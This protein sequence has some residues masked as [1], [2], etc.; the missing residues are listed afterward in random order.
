VLSNLRPSFARSTFIARH[1]RRNVSVIERACRRPLATGQHD[2]NDE[3]VLERVRHFTDSLPPAPP[4]WVAISAVII[5]IL[6]AQGVFAALASLSLEQIDVRLTGIASPDAT[7]IYD[8]ART[9]VRANSDQLANLVLSLSLSCYFVL[10]GPMSGLRIA[11]MLLNAPRALTRRNRNSPLAVQAEHWDVY[12]EEQRLFTTLRQPRPHNPP[13]D[14]LVK[15]ALFA[16]PWF[17]WVE[18]G[19][20]DLL[21]TLGAIWEVVVFGGP[22]PL[23]FL[24]I[25]LFFA[26][27]VAAPPRLAWLSVAALRRRQGTAL[28][29]A[30]A[31]LTTVPIVAHGAPDTFDF[32]A[33]ERVVRLRVEQSRSV[34]SL[35]SA[36]EAAVGN[37]TDEIELRVRGV[38]LRGRNMNHMNLRGVD[39]KGAQLS[40]ANLAFSRLPDSC[41]QDAVLRNANLAG[42]DLRFADLRGA[43]LRGANLHGAKLK[44]SGFDVQTS[45]PAGYPGHSGSVDARRRDQS[46]CNSR[47]YSDFIGHRHWVGR[48]GNHRPTSP[49]TATL[50]K[51]PRPS[52]PS[53]GRDR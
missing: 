40:D 36:L 2:D 22:Q 26:A 17:L 29:A 51:R 23:A 52:A 27:A 46:R 14:L 43:D 6:L 4:R 30:I 42:A 39:F 31:V 34:E 8:L 38:D 1:V 7:S 16:G 32:D 11:R 21:Y 5:M 25:G 28:L 15:A 18:S 37:G 12:G 9:P 48:R 47:F 44:N 20:S 33:A 41:L 3:Q 24:Y 10:R 19:L 45:W 50:R 53:A 13:L 49:A 35:A